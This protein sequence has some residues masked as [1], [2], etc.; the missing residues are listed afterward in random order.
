MLE[1]ELTSRVY[2]LPDVDLADRPD[3]SDRSD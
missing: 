3:R 2:F 1:I